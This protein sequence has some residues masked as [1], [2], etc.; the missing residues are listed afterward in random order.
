MNPIGKTTTAVL[1]G[2]LAV[3]MFVLSPIPA[4]AQG[5]AAGRKF[6]F[7]V[8]VEKYSHGNLPN[9]DFPEN[10]V[11]ELAQTLTAQKFKTLLL[12]TRLGKTNSSL[13]PTAKNVWSSLQNFIRDN[14]PDKADL[15]LIGL[16]GHG[17]Q[18]LGSDESYFC[19]ADANPTIKEGTKNSPANPDSLISIGELLKVLD[20][21]GVGYKLLI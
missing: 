15:M 19:P 9:L 10:D 20:D 17:I 3:A 11:E 16:A 2:A 8:G 13:M 5:V 4:A 6:A 18:P 14:K 7:L 12:T 21:S 1:L